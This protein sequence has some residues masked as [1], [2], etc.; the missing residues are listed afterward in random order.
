MAQIASGAEEAAGASQEQ[1]ASIKRIVIH[2]AG[3]RTDAENTGR[4][5]ETVTATLS[6]TT[7]QI[8]ASVHAMA[9]N[10]ERQKSS[11][12]GIAELN[13]R[14]ADISQITRTVSRIADQTNLLALNA[15]IEAARTGN[16]GRGFAVVAEEV[17]AL[18]ETAN[19]NAQEVDS[20]A[21]SMT[22]DMQAAGESLR[23]S[24]DR[25]TREAESAT[26]VV[27]KLASRSADMAEIDV[28]SREIV[29]SASEAERAVLEAEK[30]AEQV[31]AAAEEQSA[32]ASEAQAAVEQQAKSLQQAQLAGQSLATLTENLRRSKASHNAVEQVGAAA[33]QLSATIQELSSAATEVMAAVEQINRACQIQASAT[34]ETSAALEQIE[35]TARLA[36]QSIRAADGAVKTIAE[37]LE[38]SRHSIESLVEG[39][40][41]GLENARTSLATVHRLGAVSRKIERTVDAIALIAAQTSMLA[42]SGSIEAARV[43]ESG[44]GFA[45]VSGDIR[46]LSRESAASVEQA[47]DAVHSILDKVTTLRSDL[48][49]MVASGE[50]DVQANHTVLVLLERM[51][52]EVDELRG[53]NAR[54]VERAEA[55]LA[56]AG[57]VAAGSRQIAAAA[58]EAD[59][60]SRDA[61][62]AATEQSRG[63]EDLAAAIEE[64]ALLADELIPEDA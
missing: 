51:T 16:H 45:V 60:A 47:K 31:A 30:G 64:I 48:E 54:I 52:A 38:A 23:Q 53:A 10:A 36:E 11:V 62:S 9:R 44:G 13:E 24:S 57:E 39:V 25:A 1:S 17:R 32:G 7:A 19:K 63:A 12:A 4:R 28:R 43:G 18:A 14:A 59:V 33:E 58:E 34:Q 8:T 42:V 55:T 21:G 49:Q 3:A 46:N 61:A 20:L 35:N 29:T 2:L 50:T 40:R 5:A 56:A 37:A 26:T 15:A 6:E 41:D 22:E 27:D